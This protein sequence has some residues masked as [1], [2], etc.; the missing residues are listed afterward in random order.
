MREGKEGKRRERV[1]TVPVPIGVEELGRMVKE[2]REG[3][4]RREKRGV[5][6]DL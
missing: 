6:W 5:E 3:E 1:R 2:R 4:A